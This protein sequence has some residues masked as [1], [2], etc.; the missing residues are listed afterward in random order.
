M[1]MYI[2]KH[3]KW[4]NAQTHTNSKPNQTGSA[5]R[6]EAT[7]KKESLH[8]VYTQYGVYRGAKVANVFYL[9]K[10]QHVKLLFILLSQH[11]SYFSYF[12]ALSV[13]HSAA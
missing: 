10:T 1:F 4:T 11:Y 6:N 13:L 5:N 8:F 7:E 12:F 9:Y 3:I 2:R